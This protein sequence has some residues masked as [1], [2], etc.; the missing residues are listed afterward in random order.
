MASIF[1]DLLDPRLRARPQTFIPI[2]PLPG[3]PQPT[4]TPTPGAPPD[5]FTALISSLMAPAQPLAAA[6]GLDLSGLVQT[7]QQAKDPVGYFNKMS[8][9]PSYAPGSMSPF[10]TGYFQ[11]PDTRLAEM[12]NRTG[13]YA[14]IDPG[15]EARRRAIN[16][17]SRYVRQQPPY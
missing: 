13:A 2:D 5:P 3:V 14:P 17:Q 1:D 15:V 11:A 12:T 10:N 4:P 7:M 16:A 6:P 8:Q 9:L